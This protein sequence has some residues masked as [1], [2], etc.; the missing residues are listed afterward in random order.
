MKRENELGK[1][2]NVLHYLSDLFRKGKQ[3]RGRG[4]IALSLRKKGGKSL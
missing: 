3:K 4:E 2:S 1:F